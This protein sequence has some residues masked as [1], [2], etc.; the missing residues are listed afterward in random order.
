M[1]DER[2]FDEKS[3]IA[4]NCASFQII[5]KILETSLFV[6]LFNIKKEERKYC[7]VLR[8]YGQRQGEILCPSSFMQFIN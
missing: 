7:L 6:R 2:A 5:K 4:L 8:F 3:C 1:F